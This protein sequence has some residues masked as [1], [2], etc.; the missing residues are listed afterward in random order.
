MSTEET[1][2]LIAGIFFLLAFF[3]NV[4]FI[5][6]LYLLMLPLMLLDP[7]WL[8]IGGMIMLMSIAVLALSMIFNVVFGIL[9]LKWRSN[10]SDHKTG[11]IVVGILGIIFGGM[12]YMFG[13]SY[14]LVAAAVGLFPGLMALLAGIIAD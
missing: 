8:L 13:G 4:A 12:S 9:C 14:A 1:L 10:P 5:V 11:L 6:L 2:S 3:A 7:L